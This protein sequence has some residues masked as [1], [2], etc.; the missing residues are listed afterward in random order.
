MK[1]WIA[2]R[3]CAMQSCKPNTM[4]LKTVSEAGSALKEACLQQ[5]LSGHLY[6]LIGALG[7]RLDKTYH[8]MFAVG[9]Q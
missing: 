6:L 9:K 2:L 8:A 5:R 7:P 4:Q 3:G 1:L